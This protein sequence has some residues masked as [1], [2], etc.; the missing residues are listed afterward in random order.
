M[1]MGRQLLFF[2][3]P[4]SGLFLLIYESLLS[5][6]FFWIKVKFLP[7]SLWASFCYLLLLCYFINLNC[8]IMLL[9]QS[10]ASLFQ[11]IILMYLFVFKGWS[12]IKKNTVQNKN[13]LF[14]LV[15]WKLNVLHVARPI[16]QHKQRDALAP[17]KWFW[18]FFLSQGGGCPQ[19]WKKQTS[20][21]PRSS[22]FKKIF[23]P[24]CPF[25]PNLDPWMCKLELTSR[26]LS[27]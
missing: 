18:S 21:T 22:T 2:L 13:I 12:H 1:S 26:M 19:T 24:I 17:K 10:Q 9:N 16:I 27:S 15:W 5:N 3:L 14:M 20:W 8:L 25:P 4:L 11:I 6:Y 23:C 7:L